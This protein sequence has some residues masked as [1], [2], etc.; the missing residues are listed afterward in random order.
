[1]MPVVVLIF[2][3]AG[4]FFGL[5]FSKHPLSSIFG[6]VTGIFVVKDYL[7][8]HLF[9]TGILWQLHLGIGIGILLFALIPTAAWILRAIKWCNPKAA[10]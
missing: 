1:M 7:T 10:E 4:G 8:I 6:L 5:F 2:G 3:L 9:R